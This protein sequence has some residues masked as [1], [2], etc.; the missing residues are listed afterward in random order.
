MKI[1]FPPKMA[2]EMAVY[3]AVDYLDAWS[4]MTSPEKPNKRYLVLRRPKDKGSEPLLP[5][6][7]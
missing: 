1:K 6:K 4:E 3:E 7:E 5:P 2:L